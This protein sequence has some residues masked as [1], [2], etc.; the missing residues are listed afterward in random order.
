MFGCTIR[1]RARADALER[2][3]ARAGA[4]A[5]SRPMSFDP[6]PA[7]SPVLNRIAVEARDLDEQRTGA[8]VPQRKKPSISACRWCVR[9]SFA[10]PAAAGCRSRRGHLHCRAV[11]HA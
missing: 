11:L 3:D 8:L 4:A 7:A 1:T 2:H 9:R 6:S 10:W 5:R